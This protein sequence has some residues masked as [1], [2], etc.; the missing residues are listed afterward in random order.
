MDWLKLLR[1]LWRGVCLC[2]KVVSAY[3]FARW[4]FDLWDALHG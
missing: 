4:M 2:L 1:L 3:R